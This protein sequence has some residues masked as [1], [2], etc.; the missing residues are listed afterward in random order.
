MAKVRE[1]EL[2]LGQADAN[3]ER[4]RLQVIDEVALV[5]RQMK[6]KQG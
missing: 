4:N 3:F 5:V 2:L 6:E 1:Q